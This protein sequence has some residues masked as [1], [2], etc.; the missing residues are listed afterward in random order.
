MILV[1][2]LV[3]LDACLHALLAH[4]QRSIFYIFSRFRKGKDH[5]DQFLTVSWAES[6]PNPP[7]CFIFGHSM[8]A[9]HS[10][11][12]IIDCRWCV[13]LQFEAATVERKDQVH[14]IDGVN[15]GTAPSSAGPRHSV[16]GPFAESR[17]FANER[18][19]NGVRF[20]V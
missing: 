1:E 20:Q 15:Q 11:L 14:Q 3:C 2:F 8:F 19:Y 17:C 7:F 10:R 6:P 13:K 12:S 4:F 9:A 16:A 5:C 18:V